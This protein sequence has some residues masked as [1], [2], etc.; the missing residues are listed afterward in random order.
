MTIQDLHGIIP[1]LVTPM[2]DDGHLDNYGLERLIEHV[3]NGGVHGIFILGT[4]GEGPSLSYDLRRSMIA[5]TSVLMKKRVPLLVGITDTSID[6]SI[7]LANISKLNGANAVVVAPP[8]YFNMGQ[9]E[10]IDYIKHLSNHCPLPIFL[11]NMPGLTRLQIDVNTVVSLLK[12]KNVVG[13][14][15]SSGNMDYYKQLCESVADYP[16][17][18]GPEELLAD[19]LNL[20]GNGG[21]S[22]GANLFPKLY[23][24]LYE[25]YHHKNDLLVQEYQNKILKVSESLYHIGT[26]EGTFIR[27]LKCAL[28][29]LGICNDY[30]AL[31][32]VKYD[33][34]DVMKLRQNL[35]AITEI[36]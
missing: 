6:E 1:P 26:G 32:Y 22:G 19:S 13:I 27:G 34:K 14:K 20:G 12:L 33:S 25:A 18:N 31:P 9:K 10:F 21:V 5:K 7:D 11:Y 4:T 28:F 8:Y 24:D 29:Q 23:V 35:T 16:V 15:D 17:F 30:V 36:S 3:I 2:T